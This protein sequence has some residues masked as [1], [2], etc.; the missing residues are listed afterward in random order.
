M[1]EKE[2][3]IKAF[4]EIMK[5]E[6]DNTTVEEVAVKKKKKFKIWKLF[7][8]LL[9]LILIAFISYVYIIILNPKVII[10]TE[11]GNSIK[12]LSFIIE[13]LKVDYKLEDNYSID[14]NSKIN[15]NNDSEDMKTLKKLIDNTNLNLNYKYEKETQKASMDF[16]LTANNA[17]LLGNYYIQAKENYIKID[18]ITKQYYKLQ[19]LEQDLF[20]TKLTLEDI[21]YIYNKVLNNLS[22]NIKNEWFSKKVSLD[23]NPTV[24]ASLI[25]SRDD[26]IELLSSIRNEL[27]EDDKVIEMLSIIYSK[28]EINELKNK[29]I[30]LD[31]DKIEVII[32][33]E[34]IENKL[35]SI[36]IN[37]ID[38]KDCE[39]KNGVIYNQGCIAE[40][41]KTLIYE[42]NNNKINITLIENQDILNEIEILKDSASFELI[43]TAKD[44][45]TITL[46]GNNDG[47][48]YYSYTIIIPSI[49]DIKNK[50]DSKDIRYDEVGLKFKNTINNNLITDSV[51]TVK[52]AYDKSIIDM[53]INN[54]L[55]VSKVSDSINV[56][57]SDFKEIKSIKE[58]FASIVIEVDEGED[59]SE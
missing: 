43:S 21:D 10:A 33:K 44:N 35:D 5:D 2:E 26:C 34:I 17:N 25:I 45:K 24:T 20:N 41:E 51:I 38:E 57:V 36:E 54:E 42:K 56:D 49:Y 59:I 13:P 7:L 1:N 30:K 53:T 22:S 55:K 52:F 40:D 39:L 8:L 18:E 31:F 28:N 29:E 14:L 11:F 27:F 37:V 15:I 46:K 23:T 6:D 4:D 50:V 9:V 3:F 32:K 48:N 47:D 12:S 16:T 58:L 19:D